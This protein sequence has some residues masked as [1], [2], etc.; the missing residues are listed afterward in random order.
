[1]HEHCPH[2]A[3]ASLNSCAVVEC[4][5]LI[6]AFVSRHGQGEMLDVAGWVR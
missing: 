3:E 4:Y 1:M 5:V 2:H 6:V